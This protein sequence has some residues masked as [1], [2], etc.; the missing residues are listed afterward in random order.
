MAH[1]GRSWDPFSTLLAP[2]PDET[3]TQR[4]AR[5]A[6][7]LEA[8]RVSDEIDA[9]LHAEWLAAKNNPSVHVLIHGQGESGKA[10]LVESIGLL[11]MDKREL[12]TKA[13]PFK[14]KVT[15][16][17]FTLPRTGGKVPHKWAF[18]VERGGVEWHHFMESIEAVVLLAPVSCFDERS[19]RNERVNRFED[20]FQLWTT[21]CTERLYKKST[22]IVIFNKYDILEEKLS[23][24]VSLRAHIPSYGERP[25]DAE[26]A[27]EYFRLH[28][29]KIL[30]QHK[31]KKKTCHFFTTAK[32][33][34]EFAIQVLQTIA[35][36]SKH[37]IDL[38]PEKLSTLE[39]VEDDSSS[40]A[41]EYSFASSRTETTEYGHYFRRM[42]LS[43][44][45]LDSDGT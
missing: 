13:D 41:S 14:F 8:K 40:I 24:G 43:Q 27:V 38:S 15:I 36:D 2:P 19:P 33:D 22:L 16:T 39:N 32:I 23:S 17:D 30:R 12:P 7:E 26:H 44:A 35:K 11:C 21:I 5:I 37:E 1:L 6:R 18:Y 3:P 9:Q 25:N 42:A 28:F 31:G 29:L 20:S 4:E 10:T 34:P 45:T